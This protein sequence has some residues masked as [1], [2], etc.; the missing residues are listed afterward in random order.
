MSIRDRFARRQ[1]HQ[2]QQAAPAQ[3]RPQSAMEAF[4]EANMKD[5][6]DSPRAERLYERAL[7]I[8]SRYERRKNRR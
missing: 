2:L 7:R 4:V 6:F 5:K 3:V 8:E 1:S